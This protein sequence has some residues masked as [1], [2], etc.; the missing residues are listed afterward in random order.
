MIGLDCDLLET[1]LSPF[2]ITAICYYFGSARSSML[3]DGE[4][5]RGFAHAREQRGHADISLEDIEKR[6][7]NLLR[8]R[9]CVVAI[10][11]LDCP[12]TTL[13]YPK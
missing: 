13:V 6:A 9:L 5:I 12:G 3:Y 10:L 1:I 8:L 7:S 2:V 4:V 11:S